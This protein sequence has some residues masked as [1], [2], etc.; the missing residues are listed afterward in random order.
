MLY[1][2]PLINNGDIMKPLVAILAVLMATG[3]SAAVQQ[4]A[5]QKDVSGPTR[6]AA[7]AYWTAGYAGAE[8]AGKGC[9]APQLPAEP[10]SSTVE[11]TAKAVRAWQECQR[12]LMGALAP[13]AAHKAIPAELLATMTPAERDAATH[14]V[15]A[16]HAKFAD[17][18][19]ADAARVIAAQQA[20][21]EGARRYRDAYVDRIAHARDR[22]DSERP[23]AVR[24]SEVARRP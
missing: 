11:R 9:V 7:V 17:A 24:Q 2:H 1:L 21:R 3:A 6:E 14:H 18:A 4:N 16:V 22:R 10:H 5:A 23:D 20:W 13:E 8:L 19:Q 12:R 15:A